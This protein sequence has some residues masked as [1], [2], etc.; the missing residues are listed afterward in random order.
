[1]KD[2][3]IPAF[4]GMYE[5]KMPRLGESITEAAIITW[6][7]NVGDTIEEDEMFLEVATDKVDSEIP[8]TVSGV[9]EAILYDANAVIKI[10]ETIAII[11]LDGAV[12]NSN[13]ETKKAVDSNKQAN[14]LRS[15]VT[16]Q[17]PNWMLDVG[18]F[19]HWPRGLAEDVGSRQSVST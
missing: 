4:A 7:K 15:C 9:I 8:S 11:K 3:E 2:S 13:K 12:S 6:F 19:Q 16:V 10:G 18:C 14:K 1:M 17:L 5:F